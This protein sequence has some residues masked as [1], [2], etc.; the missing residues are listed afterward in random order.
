MS[1]QA[2]E[3]AL[4]RHILP[5]S[6]TMIGICTTLIGLVKIIEGRIGPS[7]VDEYAA[8]TSLFFMASALTSYLSIRQASRQQLSKRLELIADQCFLIGLVAIV[9]ISLFFAY[10]II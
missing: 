1:E 10:E 6:G 5:T 2:E 7:R 4:S 3:R 9:L 8:I